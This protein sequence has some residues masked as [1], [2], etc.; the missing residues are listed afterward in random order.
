MDNDIQGNTSDILMLVY[1][2]LF[3]MYWAGPVKKDYSRALRHFASAVQSGHTLA[4]FHLAQL[5]LN[6]L[7]TA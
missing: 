4:M 2:A 6:G 5:H 3:C 1:L 7:G